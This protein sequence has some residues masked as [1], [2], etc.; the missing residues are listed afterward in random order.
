[1]YLHWVANT[2]KT[3]YYN[4]KI[5]A[6]IYCILIC[7]A[8]FEKSTMILDPASP[9]TAGFLHFSISGERGTR[10]GLISCTDR[11]GH[12]E[13]LDRC[14][15]RKVLFCQFCQAF[16]VEPTQSILCTLQSLDIPQFGLDGLIF[17]MD[18][19]GCVRKLSFLH[20][21]IRSFCLRSPLRTWPHA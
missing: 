11:G 7:C 5:Y 20:A 9:Q 19:L 18:A 10:K 15:V 12:L 14:S 6:C 2:N 16:P 4:H 21:E 13:C 1:M 17:H 8:K 3:R